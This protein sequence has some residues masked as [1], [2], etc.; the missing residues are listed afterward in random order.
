MQL[1]SEQKKTYSKLLGGK[2]SRSKKYCVFLFTGVY[3]V[4]LFTGVYLFG[5]LEF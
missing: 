2:L 5:G 4:F 3:C 1:L